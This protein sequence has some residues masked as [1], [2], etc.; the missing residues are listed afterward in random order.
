MHNYYAQPI[1]STCVCRCCGPATNCTI[2]V[3]I[4]INGRVLAVCKL[5]NRGRLAGSGAPGDGL[6]AGDEGLHEVATVVDRVDGS[7]VG[8]LSYLG[9]KHPHMQLTPPTLLEC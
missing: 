6:D 2:P 7:L 8:Q 5:T 4:K 3:N 1:Y 9:L